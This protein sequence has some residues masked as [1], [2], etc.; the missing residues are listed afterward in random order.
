M[1]KLYGIK[2]DGKLQIRGEGGKYIYYKAVAER[3]L[4]EY[5]ENGFKA[6]LVVFHLL[7]EQEY[8][9]LAKQSGL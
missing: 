2:I 9:K 4:A 6:E 7:S 3:R 8:N 5:L 1:D